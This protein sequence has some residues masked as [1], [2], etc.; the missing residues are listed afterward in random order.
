MGKSYYFNKKQTN[1]F[2]VGFYNLENLFDT[3]D[4]PHILD[5]DF[6]PES[7][8]KWN[9]KRYRKKIF[10]LGTTISNIG[11]ASTGKAPALIGVAEVENKKVLEDLIHTK[12]LKNKK[13]GI[14]HFESPDERGIDVG[15]LYLKEFFEIT[16]S[17]SVELL[18]T[19]NKGKRDFTRDILWVSGKLNGEL[20]HVLVNHWPSRRDG[21]QQT[22]YKRIAAAQKNKEIIEKIRSSEPNAKVIVMGDLNDDPHSSSV[23]THL[24]AEDMYNPME[25]L[26]TR[27]EGSL[28]YRGQWNLFD[29]I[30]FTPNF[31][32]Y[33]KGQHSFSS[34]SI[35]DPDFLKVR[36]GRYKGAPLRTYGG[37]KYISGFSDHFPVYVQLKLN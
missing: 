1:L 32:K 25:R 33:E 23:K 21:A 34:A 16:H 11:F 22:S 26:H 27:Y 37:G 6:L 31:H 7:E 8:R 14:I 9:K 29:Q 28:T 12:H 19:N 30:I 36:K 2:T 35:F 17:E 10:N 5:D 15:L 3:K 4:N 24:V 18:I 13:Y 20:I